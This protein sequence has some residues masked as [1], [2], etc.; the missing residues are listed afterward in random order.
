MREPTIALLFAFLA[1]HVLWRAS[2]QLAAL[3]QWDRPLLIAGFGVAGN[4]IVQW[5]PLLNIAAALAT[6]AWG[7]INLAWY[8][9]PVAFV[10]AGIT[11]GLSHN[12]LCRKSFAYTEGFAALGTLSGLLLVT[13][14]QVLLWL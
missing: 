5:S 7:L 6:F 10:L 9:P 12:W 1:T 2:A 13:V 3:P 14:S 4:L 11:F 8:M